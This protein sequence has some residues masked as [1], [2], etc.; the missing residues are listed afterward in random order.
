MK[1]AI[2]YV[3]GQGGNAE[4]AKRY[5]TVCTGYEVFGLDYHSFTPWEAKA[6]FLAAYGKLRA[7][8]ASVTVIANS[9][10]AFFTMHALSGEAIERA[11]FI[12]PIVDMEKL[13]ADRMQSLHISESELEAK[14]E[15]ETPFGD[16]LSWQYL[17][18]VRENPIEWNVPTAI[19]YA[20]KDVLTSRE[21]VSAFAKKCQA[22]LTVME[23]GEH[24]FHTKEQLAFLDG[25][26]K[27][28]LG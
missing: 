16:A 6:E 10:G 22:T 15:I 27:D 21:T 25:W 2:L 4:E 28:L 3:H 12:S 9:I 19:L 20:G 11:F 26:L 7:E 23:D 24:W 13:I 1:K 8:Y 18:Y 17:C 14:K 5:K